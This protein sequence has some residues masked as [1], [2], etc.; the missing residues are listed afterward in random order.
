[1]QRIRDSETPQR[2]AR[3]L[4]VQNWSPVSAEIKISNVDRIVEMFGGEELYG[5]SGMVVLRELIQNSIDA[6]QLR[7]E[8]DPDDKEYEGRVS[9]SLS[10]GV[11]GDEAGYWLQV[12]DDGLGMSKS[13]LT[14]PL[15]DFGSSYVTSDLAKIERPGLASKAK[16][17]IGKYGIGF[18]SIFMCSDRVLVSSR[19]YDEGIDS[20]KTLSFRKSYALRPILLDTRQSEFRNAHSTLVSAFLTQEQLDKLLRLSIYRPT[21]KLTLEE[22]VGVICQ[23]VDVDVY[24]QS[25]ENERI[26][27]HSRDWHT[28]PQEWLKRI[29]RRLHFYGKDGSKIV[30]SFAKNLKL[31][32]PTDPSKGMACVNH[33]DPD[34]ILG[35]HC[36]GGLS[37][38]IH[39]EDDVDPDHVGVIDCRPRGPRREGGEF[40]S[41]D[42][43]AEWA[44]KEA[45]EIGE[46]NLP[47]SELEYVCQ[48]IASLGGNCA[49]IAV[50]CV[51]GE[52]L[53]VEEIADKLLEFGYLD[54]IVD[55]YSSSDNGSTL[56]I[57]CA[58]FLTERTR[59]K[60]GID[61]NFTEPT[62]SILTNAYSPYSQ[63]N[64]QSDKQPQNSLIGMIYSAM[65]ARGYKLSTDQPSNKRIGTYNGLP[66]ERDGLTIGQELEALVV[67]LCAI[68]NIKSL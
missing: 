3:H 4:E 20:V 59:T 37:A 55:R 26:K 22:A 17:R 8:L 9:I 13:V 25:F 27:I 16:E 67:R 50:G 14:G 18:F 6:I 56:F 65:G 15:I 12:D 49:S 48:R 1:M 28:R 5:R 41:P 30:E 62:L 60:V 34:Y 66:S 46:M 64:L 57:S 7:R 29:S 2:L 51:S 23:T 36:V 53:S 10:N 43:V 45:I 32:D 54:V 11:E 61:L 44:S 52:F 38:N 63:I 19:P 40:S 21:E 68:P 42:I 58:D 24:V 35:L 31:I 33:I 47:R 39:D